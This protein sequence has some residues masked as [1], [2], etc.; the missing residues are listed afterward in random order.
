MEAFV[1]ADPYTGSIPIF[2]TI[3]N[4]I[5]DRY[6]VDIEGVDPS[7]AEFLSAHFW[8]GL[9]EVMEKAK[10]WENNSDSPYNKFRFTY[11]RYILSEATPIKSMAMKTEGKIPFLRGAFCKSP[12][13]FYDFLYKRDIPP[14]YFGLVCWE[15]TYDFRAVQRVSLRLLK[16]DAQK[17]A[18]TQIPKFLNPNISNGILIVDWPRPQTPKTLTISSRVTAVASF[19]LLKSKGYARLDS[20]LST[21]SKFFLV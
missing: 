21:F 3:Q 1:G 6:D 16:N 12:P 10:A 18:L 2:D 14:L 9:E 19:G 11:P 20:E 5:A 8:N 7:D 13:L 15:I 4:Y 17:Y